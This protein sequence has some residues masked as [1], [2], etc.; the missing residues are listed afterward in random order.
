[1]LADG[2]RRRSCAR[3]GCPILVYIGQH[4]LAGVF[5]HDLRSHHYRPTFAVRNLVASDFNRVVG[6][7]ARRELG[8]GGMYCRP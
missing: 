6:I 4:A 1:M 8:R 7:F 3:S 5:P 2:H